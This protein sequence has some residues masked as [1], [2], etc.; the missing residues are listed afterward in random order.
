[1]KLSWLD[2]FERSKPLKEQPAWNLFR[3]A[4]FGE[5]FGWTLLIGGI[6]IKRYLLHGNN[7]PVLIAGQVHGTFFIIYAA[8]SVV[9]YPSLGWSRW[10]AIIATLASVPPYGS[11][12]F[13]QWASHTRAQQDLRILHRTLTYQS[14]LVAE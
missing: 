10:K 4:A 6:L 14:L 1:M 2:A 13:E 12:I 9:L 5:A 8:V 7:D 3:V 11:L